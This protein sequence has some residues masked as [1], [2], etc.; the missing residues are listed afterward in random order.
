MQLILSLACDDARLRPDGKLDIQGVFNELN[1][2]GFPAAQERMTVV[3]VMEWPRDVEGSIPF[4]ADLV[5]E[6]GQKMLTIQ[7]HTEVHAASG[8][9]APAT[10]R[11]VMPLERVVFPHPGH[12]RFVLNA[13]GERAEGIPLHLV[14]V[15]A[16]SA[17][18]SAKRL[19]GN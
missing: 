13:R 3:F 8:A 2:P 10:T 11:L 16:E 6:S 14:E 19:A 1:A 7:G 15:P 18:G 12:Y 17:A 5:D 4:R 9:G